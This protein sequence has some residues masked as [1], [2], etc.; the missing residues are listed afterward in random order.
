MKISKIV[1]MI[2]MLLVLRSASATQNYAM[3]NVMSVDQTLDQMESHA[4]SAMQ[5]IHGAMKWMKWLIMEIKL[6]Q[7]ACQINASFQVKWQL[8]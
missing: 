5:R 4:T 7:N 2:Q 3:M 1:M 8:F 6:K